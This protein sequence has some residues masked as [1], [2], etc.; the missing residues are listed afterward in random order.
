MIA[1]V[2][3]PA[4]PSSPPTPAV[5]AGPRVAR[6]SFPACA[7]WR[8]G[9]LRATGRPPR[10]RCGARSSTRARVLPCL[11]LIAKLN[12]ELG[13]GA[14]GGLTPWCSWATSAW[15]STARQRARQGAR[16][17]GTNPTMS[18]ERKRRPAQQ[19]WGAHVITLADRRWRDGRA[20]AP[21]SLCLAGR[22]TRGPRARPPGERHAAVLRPRWSSRGVG[23]AVAAAAPLDAGT[24][25]R[26]PPRRP[27]D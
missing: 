18:D 5:R 15:K 17:T 20:S 13:T 25:T 7:T 24:K 14:E 9:C 26:P 4:P 22:A 16:Q 6:T 8:T 10:T 12:R 3:R 11:D 23:S 2:T 19:S 21:T 27:K 1:T